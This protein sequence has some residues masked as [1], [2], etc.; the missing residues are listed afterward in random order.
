MNGD[1]ILLM[2]RLV[3]TE[4]DAPLREALGCPEPLEDLSAEFCRLFVGPRPVCPPYASVQRGEPMIGGR[5]ERRLKEFAAR[6]GLDVVVPPGFAVLALDHLGVELALLHHLGPGP[7]AEELLDDHV[8]P[9]ALGY[10]RSL[11][12][13]SRLEPYVSAARWCREEI[14]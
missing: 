1:V 11:E 10:L 14:T 8:R 7:V 9:W 4:I 5:A 6:H 13:A 3:S 12:E 2:S